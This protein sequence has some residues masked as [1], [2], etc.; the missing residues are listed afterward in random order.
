MTDTLKRQPWR[1]LWPS[2]KK[3]DGPTVATDPDSLAVT[4]VATT[5]ARR[6]IGNS[7]TRND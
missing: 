4:P 1:I 2:T 5:K 3:Y 7:G 6:H